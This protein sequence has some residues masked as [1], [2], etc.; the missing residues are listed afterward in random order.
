MNAAP[1]SETHTLVGSEQAFRP[2]VMVVCTL[3]GVCGAGLLAWLH[4]HATALP[5]AIALF[6]WAVPTL[7][8]LHYRLTHAQT[9]VGMMPVALASLVPVLA[10]AQALAASMAARV[11]CRF[12]LAVLLP[13]AGVFCMWFARLRRCYAH[14]PVPQPDAILIVLG[15]A[16][17]Q[18]RPC[19]TLVRRL[20]LAARL[21]RESPLRTIAVTGGP[22]PYGTTTEA[23]EMRRYLVEVGVDPAA[24]VCERT[25]RN[26][27]ENIS[28]TAHLLEERSLHGQCCIITSDYHLYRA[29]RDARRL[30]G[31]PIAIPAPTPAGSVAQQWCREVLTLLAGR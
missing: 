1:D 5:W 27:H 8:N 20:D 4:A 18:G 7:S 19:A 28:R 17:R 12:G 25:A 16:I 2:L 24:I 29:M 26:T 9:T 23:D 3:S 10:L 15:G 21:W 30:L 6:L 11:A 13:T 14:Q 31:D 22:T